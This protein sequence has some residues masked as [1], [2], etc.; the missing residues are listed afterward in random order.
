MV[1]RIRKQRSSWRRLLQQS[2]STQ[3]ANVLTSRDLWCIVSSFIYDVLSQTAKLLLL[4]ID[5]LLSIYSAL[6]STYTD[7]PHINI[8]S[9][10]TF[11]PYTDYHVI[12]TDDRPYIIHLNSITIDITRLLYNLYSLRNLENVWVLEPVPAPNSKLLR[13]WLWRYLIQWQC[14]HKR[15]QTLCLLFLMKDILPS[16]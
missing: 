9:R 3:S 4:M 10:L 13:E 12:G 5:M 11:F 15:N 16:I 2:A 1:I 7:F 6:Q 14:I 8:K